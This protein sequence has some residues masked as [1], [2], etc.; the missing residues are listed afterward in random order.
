M[1]ALGTDSLLTGL[2]LRSATQQQLVDSLTLGVI[3]KSI[4][5]VV[6][7]AF[8]LTYSRGD[9]RESLRRWRV[10]LAIVGVVPLSLALAY[11]GGLFE[12]V[13][14]AASSE[15]RL[16]SSGITRTLNV[17]LLLAVVPVLMNVE[18][19]FRSAVGTM[20][21]RIKFVVLALAVI[22]GASL[23]VRTQGMLFAAPHSAYWGIEGGGLLIGCVF[24]SVA[25][26]RT[27]LAEIEVYPSL[28]VLRSSLTILLVG[29]YLLIVGV[30]AQLVRRLGGAETFQLQAFVILLGVAVLAAALASDRARQRIHLFTARHFRRARHDSTHIW[31]LFSDHLARVKDQSELCQVSAKLIADTFSVLSV[32]VWL[33]D[34][35]TGRFEL[36]ASTAPQAAS[37]TV[38]IGSGAENPL[39]GLPQHHLPVEIEHVEAE[40][41]QRLRELNP[42]TFP[43]GGDRWC[44]VLR[45]SD[46]P[47]G[48]LVLADR[49]SGAAYTV[50]E[51]EL[52][53]CIGN[54]VTS[55]LLNLQLSNEVANARE[56]EA[57]QTMSAFF[58]HDLKNS[59]ASLNLMLKNLP[60]HFDD[61]S[62]RADALRGIGNTARRI[63]EMIARLS[64]FRHQQTPMRA[65][66]DLRRL[67][68]ETLEKVSVS[69]G[70][71]VSRELRPVPRVL[72]DGEQLRSVVTNLV[73]NAIDAVEGQ[74]VVRVG[75]QHQ[76]GRV[77]L[78]VADSGCG[79]SPAFVKNELF[80]PFRSTKTKGLGIGLYQ[81]RAIVHSHGGSIH[82]DSEPGKGTTFTVTLPA[83]DQQ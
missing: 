63:D 39:A 62:F 22:F 49:V 79:M 15:T 77:L 5:P 59:A 13:D 61:P 45:V 29:G 10:P 31:T 3:V 46:R 81:C 9:Y 24:L 25:Y 30:L 41:A 40:W 82:A 7:L 57:L 51:L 33:L 52:L 6:W 19:T 42:S 18:Q 48:L 70:V 8:S 36:T 54:Q 50:E 44:V 67:V 12:V 34:P 56:L 71:E 60:V 43:S 21:W 32:N 2:S 11:R 17:I 73:L 72:A 55:M 58:V 65:L 4:Q 74:G 38:G 66:L 28:A 64:T 75:T 27:G 78:S 37:I 47:V 35:E 80:R 20:R 83:S 68:D 23:Y 53:A 1:L 14:V 76:D 16:Q 26:A 69:P